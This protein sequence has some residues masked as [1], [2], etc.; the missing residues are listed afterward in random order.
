LV[1][2]SNLRF[3]RLDQNVICVM[4]T[5]IWTDTELDASV[6]VYLEMLS[7]EKNRIPYRKSDYRK[8]VLAGA[9]KGRSEGS[10]EFR[11]QNIS[12]VLYDLGQPFIQG[13]KPA[14]NVGTKTTASILR[15]LERNKFIIEDN[16]PTPE[17]DKLKQRTKRLRKNIR[18]ID[19]PAG[20]QKPQ[21]TETTI[22]IYYRDPAVRAWVL[23]NA[24]GKCE[25]CGSDAPFILPDGYPFLE[26]HH[27]IPMAVGGPDTIENTI[28]LCPNCHRRSHLSND[29]GS[30]NNIIY[31]KVPR[32][33]K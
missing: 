13:Y 20:Q 22:T 14:K 7:K 5:E 3:C 19:R 23:E 9:L 31:N 26:V 33:K 29:K 27:M 30:F 2:D 10:F 25:A 24:K 12:Y 1:V 6:K 18:L 28:A 15:S 17:E 8:Q 4:A 11:M 32:L 21:K 16:E